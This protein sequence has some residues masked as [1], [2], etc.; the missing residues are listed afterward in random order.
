MAQKRVLHFRFSVKTFLVEQETVAVFSGFSKSF[1]TPPEFA[2][3]SMRLP[4]GPDSER[5][6]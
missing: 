5:C 3:G 2:G 1:S 4:A 6:D